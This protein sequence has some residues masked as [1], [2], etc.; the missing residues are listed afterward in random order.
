M[1]V[2]PSS[3]TSQDFARSGSTSPDLEIFVRPLEAL[4]AIASGKLFGKSLS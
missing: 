2:F 3:F 1:K 4:A